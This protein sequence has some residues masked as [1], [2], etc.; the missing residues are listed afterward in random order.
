MLLEYMGQRM[1]QE[2]NSSAG[3]LPERHKQDLGRSD[4][5]LGISMKCLNSKI[6]TC[7]VAL[8]VEYIFGI[9]GKKGL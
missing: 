5:S 1:L 9:K 7:S 6:T 2:W 8:P 4:L 3:E